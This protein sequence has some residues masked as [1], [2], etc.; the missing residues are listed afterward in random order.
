MAPAPVINRGTREHFLRC[1][2]G[3]TPPDEGPVSGDP[4]SKALT[5]LLAKEEQN[6]T[7]DKTTIKEVWGT[8]RER[9]RPLATDSSGDR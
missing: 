4:I 2:W 3:N 7:V 8:I 5:L 9:R 6:I 1:P